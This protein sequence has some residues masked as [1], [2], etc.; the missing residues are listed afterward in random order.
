MSTGDPHNNQSLPPMFRNA[1]RA[2]QEEPQLADPLARTLSLHT[3]LSIYTWQKMLDP[4][5]NA[6][7]QQISEWLLQQE[8]PEPPSLLKRF[9]AYFR[10]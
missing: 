8:E 2:S 3:P 1:L 7:T 4:L 6:E 10:K 5:N 9:L